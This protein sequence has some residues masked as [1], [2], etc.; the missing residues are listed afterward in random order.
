MSLHVMQEQQ[1]LVMRAL[2]IQHSMPYEY[3]AA[4]G[5]ENNSNVGDAIE[6]AFKSATGSKYIIIVNF[7]EYNLQA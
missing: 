4:R 3:I 6:A 7:G 1:E 2:K 5:L